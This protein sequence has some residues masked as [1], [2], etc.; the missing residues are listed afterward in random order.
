[1][2]AI[3]SV[4]IYLDIADEQNKTPYSFSRMSNRVAYNTS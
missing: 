4:I 1:M 2:F 3:N